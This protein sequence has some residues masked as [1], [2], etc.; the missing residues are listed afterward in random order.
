MPELP[1]I[2]VKDAIVSALSECPRL[3]LQAPTGSGKSTQLPQFLIDAGLLGEDGEVIILQPRR[4]A[5]RMLAKRV[6]HER[7]CSLGGEVG[8]QIRFDNL[9]S[10]STRIRFV[11]EGILLRQILENAQLPGVAAIVFDEFH[12]RNLYT[13]LTLALAKKAQENQ[14][15]DLKLIVMSATLH[16]APLVD[17]LKPCKQVTTDGRT[18]PVEIEYAANPGRAMARNVWDK[19][20]AVAGRIARTSHEGDMLIFMPGAREIHRTLSALEKEGLTRTFECVPLYGELSPQM[21]DRALEPSSRR[22]IIVSTNIAE[23]SLTIPTITTVID[24]GLARVNRYDPHRGINSLLVESICKSSAEQRAGRAGR[25]QEGQCI[26][27]WSA[28]DQ[29]YRPDRLAPEIH[30][31]DL[32]DTLLLLK[33]SGIHKMDTLSWFEKPKENLIEQA[34]VLL[35]SLGALDEDETITEM[36][37]RMAKFPMHPRYAR[38]MIGAQEFDCVSEICDAVA[39]A[40]ERRILLPMHDNRKENARANMLAASETSDF[41]PIMT[42][43]RMA[44]EQGFDK[45]FCE[46]WGIHGVAARRAT[47]TAQQYRNIAERSGLPVTSLPASEGNIRRSLMC[48]FIDHLALRTNKGTL[49]CRLTGNKTGELRRESVARESE[50][51]VAAEIEEHAGSTGVKLMLG[52]ATAI[53]PEW[54]KTW[55]PKDFKETFT[56]T[57]DPQQK[58]VVARKQYCFRDLVLKEQDCEEVPEEQAA[59][60]LCEK[61][62][63]GTLALKNWNT[64]A[65]SLIARIN[66]AA[67]RCPDYGIQKIDTEGK[68]LILEQLCLGHRSYKDIKEI[69]P[70]PALL[71]WLTQEQQ[72]ALES[73]A[74]KEWMLPS[75]KRPIKLRYEEHKVVLAATIQELYDI[76]GDSLKIGGGEVPLTIELLAPNRRPIQITQDLDHFWNGSYPAVKKDLKG[77]YPKHEWR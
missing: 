17:Y 44:Q 43:V 49:H 33:A 15:P 28:A 75:K 29:I 63:D 76:S 7:G 23:T 18:F 37:R 67:E 52:M 58:R 46:Q 19:A 12:E 53:E 24:S 40:E 13:D 47:Q 66:F 30:R 45:H 16:S 3:V 39:I 73:I 70:M 22:K 64:E 8:Y 35:K 61:L 42:A 57:Y 36:G 4:V 68:K 54:L 41:F 59:R 72:L 69:D 65:E 31:V 21:Q 26:R 50:L 14:R 20:A 48:G 25:V 6:A 71:D 38:L 51:I 55:F 62:M 34:T 74:P 1:I 77:R 27:L 56:C 10:K 11:T 9:T 2:D 32:S 60:L 5:A